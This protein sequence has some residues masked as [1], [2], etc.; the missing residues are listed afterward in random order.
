MCHPSS[1]VAHGAYKVHSFYTTS[2]L[3]WVHNQRHIAIVDINLVIFQGNWAMELQFIWE[4]YP[5]RALRTVFAAYLL[6]F[7][8]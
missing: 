3:V 7:Y 5:A 4:R 1:T 6:G 2:E 8:V